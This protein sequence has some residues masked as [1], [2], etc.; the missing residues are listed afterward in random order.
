MLLLSARPFSPQ[1]S[2]DAAPRVI[3]FQALLSGS[4]PGPQNESTQALTLVSVGNAVGGNVVISNDTVIFTPTSN[5]NGS[6]SFSYLAQ[7]NGTTAGVADPKT[8][9]ATASF[10]ILPSD[11]PPIAVNDV[12]SSVA[13][14][15]GPRGISF[16]QLLA[17]DLAGPIDEQGQ[18]LTIATVGGATGG[19][20]SIVGTN[21]VFFPAVDFYGPAN[22][23]YTV[24]DNLGE[25]APGVVTFNITEVNDPPIAQVSP[26]DD[27]V[28]RLGVD[29]SIQ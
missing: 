8:N 21:V 17:N 10:E 13:E 6:A 29:H 16:N 2:E 25:S 3:S 22:F 14:D 27:V 23:S 9:S 26:R 20:V 24:R 1:I 28:R 4:A 11:D 7:D 19:T 15:S 12:L 18:S 5:Y